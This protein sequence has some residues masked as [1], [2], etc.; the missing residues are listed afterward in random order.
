MPPNDEIDRIFETFGKKRFKLIY[1]TLK[2]TIFKKKS[3]S[4]PMTMIKMS[5]GQLDHALRSRKSGLQRAAVRLSNY[6][7][8]IACSHGSGSLSLHAGAQQC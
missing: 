5:L 1:I 8:T 2:S 4:K 6:L 3:F 7:G